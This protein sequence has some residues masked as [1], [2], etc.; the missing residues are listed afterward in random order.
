M[1]ATQLQD[2]V[3]IV[4]GASS[5]IGYASAK[6][7]AQA[8]AKVVA[9]A[10]REYELQNLAMEVQNA[11]GDI[12]IV[13]GN[14]S[15]ESFARSLVETAV[16]TYGGLHVAFNNAG[17]I[18]PVAELTDITAKQWRE[19]IDTNLSGAFFAAKH[20][21]PEMVKRG[22]GSVIFTSSFVGNGIGLPGMC[23]YAASKAGLV[24]LVQALAVE[25]G[26]RGI[27]VNALLPGG[28]DTPMGKSFADTPEKRDY[29]KSIHALRRI[30]TPSEI[31]RAA[32]FLASD[33]SSF[34]TGSSL[35]VDGGASICKTQ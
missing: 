18:G 20:Q 2:K 1:I 32:L 15:D 33:A 8:G 6:L 30:A 24:G 7:F 23:A 35:V 5:G 10:R 22:R 13:C 14:V 4:T 34:M 11:G 17:T 16:H 3:A 12:T 19:V 9:A 29:V 25:Y 26:D 31:A 28:T 27:R 21:I